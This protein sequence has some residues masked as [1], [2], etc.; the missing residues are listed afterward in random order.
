MSWW[1]CPLAKENVGP[2]RLPRGQNSITSGTA[3]PGQT[4]GALT[5]YFLWTCRGTVEIITDHLQAVFCFDPAIS[6]AFV[7]A[8]LS[9]I[10]AYKQMTFLRKYLP[11]EIHSLQRAE[12]RGVTYEAN[13]SH[14]DVHMRIQKLDAT[15]TTPGNSDYIEPVLPCWAPPN[16]SRFDDA[17]AALYLGDDPVVFRREYSWAP[18]DIP[19]VEFLRIRMAQIPHLNLNWMELEAAK[20]RRNFLINADPG[21]YPIGDS[22]MPDSEHPEDLGFPFF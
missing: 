12:T 2:S 13:I 4:I 6:E 14:P 3:R 17:F 7:A 16:W 20:C 15:Q 18:D 21:D 11:G 8:R 10:N 22:N 1:I 9:G 19:S 5:I